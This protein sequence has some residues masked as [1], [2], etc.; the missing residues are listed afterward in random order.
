MK[1]KLLDLID[2]IET[3]KTCFTRSSDKDEPFAATRTIYSAPEFVEWSQSLQF[4]LQEI[5]DRTHNQF[6]F[7]TLIILK[8]KF[9]GWND[10]RFFKELS[11]KLF[12]IKD[13][14]NKFFPAEIEDNPYTE[15]AYTMITKP[16]KIFISHSSDD[17]KYVKPLVDLLCDIG[18]NANH[19]F[20]SSVPGY[21][22]PL[23]RDIYD[24]LK[25]QFQEYDLHVF[26]ILS[27]NYYNSPACLNEMGAAWIL[28]NAYTSILLPGF[29]F[30]EIDGAV[31]PRKMSIKLDEAQDSLK[32][33]LGQLK[34]NL[35]KEFDLPLVP[36]TWWEAK[37]DIFITQVGLHD[38]IPLISECARKLLFTAC[39]YSNGEI[40]KTTRL[41]GTAIS[42]AEYTFVDSLNRREIAEWESALEELFALG[43]VEITGISK[44]IYH[45]KKAGYD[46]VSANDSK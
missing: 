36:D 38:D 44:E 17:R 5:Y 33:K 18:L 19:I 20:C 27:S 41:S 11:G 24:F 43:F 8:Q 25:Q 1:D 39:K 9:N 28:Q 40:I 14:I 32:E 31:N 13:N 35:I 37:R 23:D 21:G 26:F 3:V 7:D 30:C 45:V 22:I 16:A 42:A 2:G 15:G 29:E 10:E 34:N 4:E 6:I 46:Y 12:V